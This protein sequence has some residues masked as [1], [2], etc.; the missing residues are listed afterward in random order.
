M[1]KCTKEKGPGAQAWVQTLNSENGKL[2]LVH[3]KM[4]CGPVAVRSG[5]LSVLQYLGVVRAFS[6]SCQT[7]GHFVRA[8]HMAVWSSATAVAKLSGPHLL[9]RTCSGR[10]GVIHRGN[11][12]RKLTQFCHYRL[13][14]NAD[15]FRQKFLCTQTSM[16]H[17]PKMF[18]W[19]YLKQ[20]LNWWSH[21]QV[22]NVPVQ[23]DMHNCATAGPTV[24]S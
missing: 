14:P 19:G 21:W 12:W 20:V 16:H 6:F 4:W 13:H 9:S 23:L 22:L 2:L 8:A 15:G 18:F 1:K 11:M 10:R 3:W 24:I 17:S 7:R 5:R